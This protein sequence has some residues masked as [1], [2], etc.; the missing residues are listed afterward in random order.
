MED[1][2][3]NINNISSDSKV[4]L[5]GNALSN[6][7]DFTS[8]VKEH[9]DYSLDKFKSNISLAD[10]D[11][12]SS[13]DYIDYFKRVNLLSENDIENLD[14]YDYI[15]LRYVLHLNKFTDEKKY[16]IIDSLHNKLNENGSMGI[17]C[18][19]KLSDDN[20]YK[21]VGLHNLW[22]NEDNDYIS[23]RYNCEVFEASDE[24]GDYYILV[25]E[26]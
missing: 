23:Q 1:I 5:L 19:Y 13:D 10:Y 12:K 20:P 22:T 4:L 11:Y 24:Q 17:Q 7:F 6:E 26:K 9:I 3:E 18:Y 25:I 2:Y 14:M 16:S 8:K 15:E 21:E